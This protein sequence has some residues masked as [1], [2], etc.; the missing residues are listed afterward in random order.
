MSIYPNYNIN[1]QLLE[2]CM[3]GEIERLKNLLINE[4][5]IKDFN[6]YYKDKFGCSALSL[7]TFYN[8]LEIVKFLVIDM[9][10]EIKENEL[11]TIKNSNGMDIDTINVLLALLEKRNMLN[12]LE[13]NLSKKT[14]KNNKKI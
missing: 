6:L 13:S 3:T 4:H 2:F 11:N 1:E 10:Y 14:I 5:N 12:K 9:N 7:A 8:N